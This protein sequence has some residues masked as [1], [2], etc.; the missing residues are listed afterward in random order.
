MAF[1]YF[2]PTKSDASWGNYWNKTSIENNLKNCETDG[3]LPVLNNYL[4][5][6]ILEAG[7]GL[8][9][10]VIYLRRRGFDVSGTDSFP[11]AVKVLKAY[12][13][14]LPVK[15]DKVEDSSYPD[16]SFDVYLSFGVVEHFEEGPQKALAEAYRLLKPGG[17]AIIETPCD[18][19]FRRLKRLRPRNR[20]TGY[21]YEYR[22]TPAELKNFIARAG[23]KILETRPKDDLSPG[24][25]IGLWLDF[26]Q[27]RENSQ[28][29][30]RLN[31]AGKTLK[32]LLGF[33]PWLWS[34][35]VVVVAKKE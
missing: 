2:V 7:C 17:I 26:P 5:G 6:R 21:F 28:P 8:G 20:K 3:L 23:F 35:C 9:K 4:R 1:K 31:A 11:G 27:L 16:K 24:K 12:D 30:F 15:V 34:A 18:N 14:T 10:W 13:K 22:Y 32:F 19:I 29:D 25:S 33:W